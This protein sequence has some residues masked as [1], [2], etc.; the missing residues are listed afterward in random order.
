[1]NKCKVCLTRTECDKAK[2]DYCISGNYDLFVEDKL[3]IQESQE[4]SVFPGETPKINIKSDTCEYCENEG[5]TTGCALNYIE[6]VREGRSKY[7]RKEIILN[8]DISCLIDDCEK[9]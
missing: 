7:K 8:D 9:H 3:F 6:C 5:L 1:M 4:A 2:Q